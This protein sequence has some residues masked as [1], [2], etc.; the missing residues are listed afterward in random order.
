MAANERA[1]GAPFEARRDGYLLST[2]ASRIDL[3]AVKRFLDASYWARGIPTDVVE[4]SI[5]GSLAFGL[6]APDG[7]MIGLARVITDH[8]TFAYLSDVWIE[9]EH[10]GRGLSKWLVDEILAHPGLAGLRRWMLATKDAHGLY[11]RAG[12]VPLSQPGW[13]MEIVAKDPYGA[14][15]VTPGERPET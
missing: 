1:D 8:A 7:A 6:Y 9:P 10:R 13:W 2:D 14:E 5:R 4:R 11:A 3:A 15:G 12:F